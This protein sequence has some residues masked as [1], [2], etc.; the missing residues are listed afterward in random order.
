MN[1]KLKAGVLGLLVVSTAAGLGLAAG[2]FRLNHPDAVRYP[3]WNIDVSRHQGRVD[4]DAVARDPRLGFAYV[5]ATEGVTWQDPMFLQ[6]WSGAQRAHLRVGA[7][8]F[9]TFCSPAQ[10]QAAHFLAVV[11]RDPHALPPA[12]DLEFGGNCRRVPAKAEARQELETWLRLVEAALGRRPVVYVT[13]EAYQE[14]LQ[15]DD[16]GY[17]LWIRDIWTSPR[18][19]RSW[20]YWQFANRGRLDG[21]GGFVDLNVFNGSREEWNRL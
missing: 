4:W 6:N 10:E 5:K 11:P 1:R 17:E 21:V 7:Y 20:S 16:T 2:V 8:H 12:V 15:D 9:L 3:I 14:F 18:L 19:Q 13:A